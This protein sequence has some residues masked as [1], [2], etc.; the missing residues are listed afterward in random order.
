MYDKSKKP[1]K[2]EKELELRR[3]VSEHNFDW[4]LR[5]VKLFVIYA[6]AI[7]IILFVSW[8][9]FVYFKEITREEIVTIVKSIGSDGAKILAAFFV[10]YLFDRRAQS[11]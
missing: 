10:K 4:H 7:G 8:C 1:I 5:S 9:G 3:K 2:H 11:T 6:A